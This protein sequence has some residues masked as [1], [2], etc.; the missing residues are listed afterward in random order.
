VFG[1]VECLSWL[2]LLLLTIMVW[3]LMQPVEDDKGS[4]VDVAKSYMQSLP[5]WQSPLLGSRKFKTPPSGGV[6]INVYERKSKLS[7]PAKVI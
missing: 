5:P 6:H 7:S 2:L 1:L 4:P 3:H